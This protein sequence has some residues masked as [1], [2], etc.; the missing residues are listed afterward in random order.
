MR[1]LPRRHDQAVRKIL[2]RSLL[3]R[4]LLIMLIPLIVMQAIALQL[5]YGSHLQIVSRRFSSGIAGEVSVIA[6]QLERFPAPADQAWL[7]DAAWDKLELSVQFHPGERI[8]ET[9][10][11]KRVETLGGLAAA[12]DQ[13][14]RRRFV[15][16]RDA[17]PRAVLIRVQMESGVLDVLA[18][19]KRLYPG[20]AYLFLLWLVGSSLLLFGIS[21]LFMRNQVRALRRLGMAA[22]AFGIGRDI[23]P[24]KPEGAAEIRQ[25]ASA[26]NR[27]QERIR[28]FLQQRTHMLAGVSHDLRTPLTRLRLAL[29]LLSHHPELSADIADMEADIA[30]M[31]RMIDGYLAFARGE[32]T[33]QA[34]PTDLAAVM[35]DIANNARRAG[36]DVAFEAPRALIIPLRTDAIRRA[37]TNLVDNARRHAQ[38]LTL[39]VS[40]PTTRSVEILVDDDG[41][42]IAPERREQVFRPFDSGAAGGTGLGLTIARDII[43]AHGGDISLEE[44]PAGGLRARILLPF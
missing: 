15:L 11:L 31:D 13:R 17:D 19:M 27:M 2:P 44:S 42:G 24:I 34:R 23:G 14:V 41:P 38:H 43:R 12:L 32:G 8:A 10:F 37:I 22:E 36:A 29:A 26:F 28:R 3:G 20:T 39:A 18:P 7:I 40:Q 33:E 5:F 16:D 6:D 21:A 4:S 35:A 30:E 1:L 25:A 9:L